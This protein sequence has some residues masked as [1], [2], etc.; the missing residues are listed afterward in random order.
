MT[1][2]PDPEQPS[3]LA[4]QA[5][6][7][8]TNRG[9][10]C[11]KGWTAAEPLQSTDRLTTP[12]LR[13]HKGAPLRPATWD[14]AMARIVSG[15]QAAQAKAG[16]DAVGIFGGG[17]LTN[18]K[19]YMLGKFARVAL[20]TRHIDYNGR[21][22]MASGAAA[23]IRAFGLDRGLPF[24]LEDIPGADT[25]LIVGS[26]PAETM[27]PIMQFF[28]AQR[29]RGGQLIVADPRRTAT[30]ETATLHLQPAPGPTPP[31]PTASCTSQSKTS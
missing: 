13:D 15:I 31:S 8:P 26:N 1:L 6:D 10:M 24:P 28:D 23:G 29:A 5:L 21:F 22:C 14:E 30:A 4:A 25:I 11:R 19:A 12:L 3:R 2:A 16:P 17:G 9:G 7:F 27:P 18:E 20:R